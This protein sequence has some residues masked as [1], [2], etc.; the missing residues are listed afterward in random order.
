VRLA[1]IDLGSNTIRLL[2]ADTDPV[3]ALRPVHGEQVM[4]RL[5][6][7]LA[8]S[9]MLEVTATARAHAVV[10]T[11]RERAQALGAER[12]VV[13]ATAAVRQAA[14]RDTLISLLA[15]EPGLELRV[16]S[17]EAEAR[18]TL[19]GVMW[20]LPVPIGP[21]HLAVCVM[22]IGGGS[23]ELVVA[24]GVTALAAVSL[25]LGCVALREGFLRTDPVAEAEYTA[26][27]AHVAERLAAEA[28]AV[29]RPLGPPVLVG[30]AGTITTLAALDL[31]LIAYDPARV[32]GHRLTATRIRAL[33]DRLGPLPLAERARTP[34]LQPGR[35]DLIVPGIT[36]ALGVLDGL[37]L[38]ELTVSDT[39]L[40]EGILLDAIGW[41]PEPPASASATR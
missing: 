29:I 23:T 9:G 10:R 41:V 33:R 22:D 17:G 20:G 5:S 38:A 19:L 32:Q 1:G 25:P 35:A 30:T 11:F 34:G 15:A 2:V 26:C 13:V 40:R 28:W 18:L 27:A 6:E 14:N 16:V 7:G 8:R 39:G 21:G 3:R 24:R 31:G 37:G 12:I 4:A 36:I